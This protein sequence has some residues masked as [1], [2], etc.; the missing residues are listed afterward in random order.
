MRV[1]GKKISREKP[2]IDMKQINRE[3]ILDAL[4]QVASEAAELYTD[5]PLDYKGRRVT[6][7]GVLETGESP[8]YVDIIIAA[9]GSTTGKRILDVG[10][11]YGFYDVVLKRQFGFEVSGIDH[12]DNMDAYCR[13]P[14]GQG[15]PVL[16]C[17]LHLDRIPYPDSTFDTVIASELIEHLLMSPKVP[18]SKINRV[19]KTG[20]KL[21][22]T[23][24]NFA[25]LRNILLLAAGRNPT[26]LF[27]E[28]ILRNKE[29]AEDSRVHPRE[30]T[31]SEVKA[32]LEK[33]GFEISEVQM[34]MNQAEAQRGLLSRALRTMMR[35]MPRYRER[36]IAIGKKS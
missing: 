7:M 36:I 35:I 24:P 1:S 34:R 6:P 3:A 29:K 2:Y 14:V 20:G 23:T 28:E 17:D 15:I 16:P 31:V 19:L 21:I 27:P 10:I 5:E 32:A 22:V 33:A 8:Q 4:N 9:V 11:A 13:Y 25:S 30:Y 26:A 12:P 18:F